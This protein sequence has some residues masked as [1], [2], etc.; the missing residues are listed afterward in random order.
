MKKALALCLSIVM[1]ATTLAAC[2]SSSSTA[3]SSSK[4]ASSTAASSTA[5]SSKAASSTATSGNFPTK[6]TWNFATTYS[7]TDS[8]TLA[9]K[10]F[11]ELINQKTNGA[12]TVN[13]TSD[14]GLGSENDTI[15]S[16]TAGDLE[17]VGSGTG[18]IFLYTQEY[19]FLMGVFLVDTYEQWTNLWNS[20]LLDGCR[21]KLSSEYNIFSVGGFGYRG[22]RNYTSNIKFTNASEFASANIKMRMNSN[23]NWMGSWKALG[24][25]PVTIALGELYGSLSNGTVSAAEGPWTQ[26]TSNALQ[27]VQKYCMETKHTFEGSAIW[28]SQKLYDSLPADYQK[29]VTA[30]AKEAMAY[31]DQIGPEME[32]KEL[33]KMIDAGCELV[34]IDRA[35]FVAAAKPYL[36]SCF[37]DLW[38]VTTYDAVLKAAKG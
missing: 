18:P 31:L 38:T 3:A 9:Y 34:T 30:A 35:S 29:A 5:A 4:A 2:G 23:P 17:F 13:V 8:A 22:Y 25:T 24:C 28:M 12:V 33:Q 20:S 32:K 1:M 16:V 6:Y 7:S 36:E 26:D 27:E 37:K 14:G 15:A 19:S 11:A 21:T 10:K